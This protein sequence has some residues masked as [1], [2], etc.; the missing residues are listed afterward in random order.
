MRSSQGEEMIRLWLDCQRSPHTRSC[1]QRDAD[2]LV[3]F[4]RKPLARVTLGDLQRFAQSLID[5]GLAPVSRLRTIA[6]VK[7][8]F[9]FG[10]RMYRFRTNPAAEL[11]LP[12]YANCLA[13]RI[14]PEDDV[15]RILAA[16]NDPRDKTLLNLIYV[17]GVRVSE[18]TQ[19][20]WRNLRPR[21][22][23][24]QIGVFGK[25]GRTRSIVLPATLWSELIGLRGSAGAEEPVFQSRTGHPGPRARPD[26]RPP[27]GGARWRGR[28]REP[29]LAP[30]R[31]R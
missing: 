30:P 3:E 22:D 19:L 20:R 28:Q 25:N 4:V 15:Q 11:P 21:G 27:G 6:A 1:Y 9:G 5:S 17:A 18:A 8:L 13:E 16:E 23:A 24:G 7:S 31:A 29:P 26:D 10:S 14:L 12:P 2:R